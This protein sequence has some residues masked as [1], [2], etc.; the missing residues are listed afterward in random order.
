MHALDGI[1]VLDLGTYLA[2]PFCGTVLG[3]FGA[4]V[5]KVERPETGD[6]LRR[7][8]TDTDCGDT[9]VWLSESR[10]KRSVT[11]DLGDPRGLELLRE[12][13]TTADV[14]IENFTPR[15]MAQLGLDDDVVRQT[16]PAAVTVRMPAYGLDGPWRDRVGFAQTI[17][18]LTGLAWTTGFADG[19]PVAPRGVADPL[20]GLHAVFATLLG[21]AQRDQA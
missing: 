6:N 4:E 19:P 3:E 9:L 1:R 21:L 2:G 18:Q 7:F 13:I 12:L 8:G 17:E 5:I 15:V 10:N 14:V 16:N 11:L 20:A